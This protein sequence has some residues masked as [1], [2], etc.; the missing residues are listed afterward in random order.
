MREDKLR[1]YLDG[2]SR[3]CSSTPESVAAMVG[4]ADPAIR[5]ADVNSSNVHQG[6][7]GI[8]HICGLATQIYLGTTISYRALLCDGQQWSARWIMSGPRTDGSTFTCRGA[9][10]GILAD[11]GRVLE[12]TDYWNRGELHLDALPA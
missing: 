2:W 1:A 5:F 6:H 8:R 4:N 7:D 9:S 11:D 12:H 10:A 3:I